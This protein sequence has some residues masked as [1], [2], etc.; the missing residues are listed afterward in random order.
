VHH[1]NGTNDIFEED[2]DVLFFSMHRQSAGF[3][4][5]TG[6]HEDAGKDT[7]KGYTVN[8][9]LDANFGDLDVSHVFRFVL[10]PLLERFRP[11]AIF[12][13]AGF[14][15]V[16][17]DPL[18]GC[19]VSPEC[20]GWMTRCLH[21][22]ARHY[23]EGRLFLLL[24]GGYNP[25]MISQCTVECVQALVV[26]SMGLSMEQRKPSPTATPAASAAPT[27]AMSPA[28][29]EMSPLMEALASPALSAK[30]S[31][32]TFPRAASDSGDGGL[33]TP[34]SPSVKPQKARTAANKTVAAVRKLTELHHLLPLELP[35]APKQLDGAGQ[36]G[37]K[38]EKKNEK[39]RLR[40]RSGSGVG[41]GEEDGASSDSSGWAIALGGMSD[42]D[43]PPT[44]CSAA[45]CPSPA[46]RAAGPPDLDLPPAFGCLGV[47]REGDS[48]AVTSPRSVG[49]AP[50]SAPSSP[51]AK[52]KGSPK[53]SGK[54][55][56][57]AKKR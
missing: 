29:P 3:F 22:L 7:G 18:G 1:G 14:D 24:E 9:P 42:P 44:P 41:S 12:V 16:K 54:S 53:A 5:G 34:K 50:S 46:N 19:K 55:R 33:Q 40:K 43:L 39:R 6:F 11:E 36:A 56:S 2:P 49:S 15:A 4:P 48:D 21:R 26:E 8:V 30:S 23:C 31:P 32:M 52:S 27:P 25:D 20:Y 45:P 38:N 37:N 13:S 35:L 10:C 28:M 57:R 51:I 47:G 17:G